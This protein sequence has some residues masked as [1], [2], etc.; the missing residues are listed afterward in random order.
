MSFWEWVAVVDLACQLVILGV[1]V[2]LFFVRR[3]LASSFQRQINEIF[4][5]LEEIERGMR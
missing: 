2:S 4:E 3:S 5:R 1:L